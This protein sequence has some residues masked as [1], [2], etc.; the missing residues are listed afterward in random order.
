MAITCRTWSNKTQA[1]TIS[2]DNGM[3]E[4]DTIAEFNVTAVAHFRYS[5][6]DSS[7]VILANENDNYNLELISFHVLKK[8]I[9][10]EY[11]N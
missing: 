11:K 8:T 9:Q 4:Y 2:T 7:M 6:F 3:L 10:E 5:S 1:S